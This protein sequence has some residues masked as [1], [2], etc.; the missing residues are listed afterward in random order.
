MK[1]FK[2]FFGSEKAIIGM[3]HLRALPGS[4]GWD[5][6]RDLLVKNAL[7]DAFSLEAGGVNAL[8]IENFSDTPYTA[9]L[10]LEQSA[11]LASM[12]ALI[13]A[14]SSIPTGVDA[15]FCDYKSAFACALAAGAEF[16]RLA[17]FVDTVIGSS[18]VMYPCCGE[19]LKYRKQIRAEHIKI[20][21]DIQ[22]KYTHNLLKSVSLEESAAN[23]QACGADSII[24][25]GSHTGVATP[26]ETIE[27][28][29]KVVDI[30]LII[31]SGF[32]RQ[33][34]ATQIA[35]ADGAIVGTSLKVQGLV[36]Q[37]KVADLIAVV[38]GIEG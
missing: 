23:A 4:P 16:V 36:D 35:V 2:D 22:V 17:V 18:G 33:N 11:A 25:T 9:T 12:T 28:T 8:M 34:A 6:N 27:R 26:M 32:N 13:K 24:V 19:A 31:G 7:S 38:K 20:L 5:G 29:R 37:G 15:A 1:W 3:V 10:S 21:A 30:P 14:K